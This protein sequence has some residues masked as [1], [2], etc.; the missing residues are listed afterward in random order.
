MFIHA[1]VPLKTETCPFRLFY[2][3]LKCSRHCDLNSNRWVWFISSGWQ[4]GFPARLA[5]TGAADT[6]AAKIIS[7]DW[8]CCYKGGWACVCGYHGG[9]FKPN[10]DKLD[11]KMKLSLSQGIRHF[12]LFCYSVGHRVQLM[13]GN[14][15]APDC[16]K[17]KLE[18]PMPCHHSSLGIPA[19][20][21]SNAKCG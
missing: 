11:E 13:H 21:D 14:V 20:W 1:F 16:S 12:A 2:S 4:T 3:W 18:G 7:G 8:P 17:F 15:H 9:S 10:Y 6:F 19:E 5:K